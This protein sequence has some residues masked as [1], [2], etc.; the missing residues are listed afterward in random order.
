MDC[1]VAQAVS[2]RFPRSTLWAPTQNATGNWD[3]AVARG[4]YK[5]FLLEN[6]G[7]EFTPGGPRSMAAHKIT[8]DVG[9]LTRWAARTGPPVFYV[10]PNPPWTAAPPP[11]LMPAAASC[12]LP[13]TG[14]CPGCGGAHPT[15]FAEWAF[16][17][18]ADRLLTALGRPS[19]A[20]VTRNA[21][22][23]PALGTALPLDRFLAAVAACEQ[24]P[25]TPPGKPQQWDDHDDPRPPLQ[26][27]DRLRQP[28]TGLLAVH[29]PF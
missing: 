1:W 2:A 8:L 14:S 23:F 21:S 20:S 6:K 15:G 9:Q 7:C 25:L 17:I 24:V 11:A 19:T 12:A 18:R 29:I 13:V 27:A 3:M 22:A 5:A 16:V 4:P 26:G 28:R 10:L